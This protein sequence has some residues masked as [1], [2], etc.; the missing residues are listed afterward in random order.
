MRAG[1]GKFE[2]QKNPRG[3]SRLPQLDPTQSKIGRFEV[4]E[5]GT[6]ERR[7]TDTKEDMNELVALH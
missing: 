4:P 6:R 7:E 1:R 2:E 5:E 3:R